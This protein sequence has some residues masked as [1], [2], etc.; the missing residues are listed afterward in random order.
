MVLRGLSLHG[1]HNIPALGLGNGSAIKGLQ[2]SSALFV[3]LRRLSFGAS[4][5]YI[6][7]NK[8]CDFFPIWSPKMKQ[9]VI[10]EVSIDVIP[11]ILKESVG[12]MQKLHMGS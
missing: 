5:T 7:I 11:Y 10:L 4:S 8:L 3:L 6:A 12:H 2:A 9:D 1:S